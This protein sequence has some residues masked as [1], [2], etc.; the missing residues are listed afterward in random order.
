MTKMHLEMIVR[1]DA[2]EVVAVGMMID[3]GLYDH[4][5][6]GRG[7]SPIGDRHGVE[8]ADG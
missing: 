7:A 2:F 1:V 4:H 3:R 8:R 5:G 6:D